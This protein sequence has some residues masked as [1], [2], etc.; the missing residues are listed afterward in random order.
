MDSSI[1]RAWVSQLRQSVNVLKD[2][3]A[4][5]E[6]REV[7]RIVSSLLTHD[8]SP[9]AVEGRTRLFR[10]AMRYIGEWLQSDI[11]KRNSSLMKEERRLV[12]MRTEMSVLVALRTDIFDPYLEGNDEQDR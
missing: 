1:A 6:I 4:P 12:A 2:F 3:L 8:A 9:A 5:E 10:H 11:D 7:R